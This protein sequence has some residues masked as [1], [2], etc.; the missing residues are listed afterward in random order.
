MT[1][2]AVDILIIGGGPAGLAVSKL[3]SDARRPHL[4]LERG[5]IAENWRSYRWDSFCLSG[6]NW[7]I[8]LPGRIYDGSAPWGYMNRD[9][10]AAWLADYARD[11]A[12]P[13]RE[14][15]SATALTADPDGD[16]FRVTTTGGDYHA[17][18][19]VI[20]IGCSTHPRVPACAA[21]L[22]AHIVQVHSSAYRS[23]EALPGGAVLVVGSGQSAVQIAEDLLRAGRSAFLA[24][25]SNWWWPIRY[26][27]QYIFSWVMAL[28]GTRESAKKEA[29]SSPALTGKDGGTDGGRLLNVHVLARMG[30]Q[31]LG[32]LERVQ[33]RTLHFAPDLATQ[34]AHADDEARKF[35]DDIDAFIEAAGLAGIPPDDVRGNPDVW[36]HPA[37]P[38]VAALDLDAAGIRTVLWATG[39]RLDF[40]W[41]DLPAFDADGYPRHVHGIGAYPGLYFLGL[42]GKDCVPCIADDAEPIVAAIL[43]RAPEA[44]LGERRS[45]EQGGNGSRWQEAQR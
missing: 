19:V 37:Q 15:V 36:T 34:V 9:E 2:E 7:T 44:R 4:V 27:G 38:P 23:P 31:L 29:P 13:V 17:R 43:N 35:L 10:I 26:R 45:R 28:G 21:D 24:A 42:P 12:V 16:G 40:A 41:I 6:P 39:H 11:F 20:A 5:R 25:G 33:G 18:E 8:R 1:L 14:G 32:R 30:V 22:P 3:L